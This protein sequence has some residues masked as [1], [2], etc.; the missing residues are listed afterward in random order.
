MYPKNYKEKIAVSRLAGLG[1]T[2]K[3][4]ETSRYGVNALYLMAH[5]I[6]E[7]AWGTV[8]LLSLKKIFM[9]LMRRT[10]MQKLMQTFMRPSKILVEAAQFITVG[11]KGNDG[12]TNKKQARKFNG[13][14][15]GNKKDGMNVRYASDPF[16]GEKYRWTYV[17]CR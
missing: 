2:F 1:S 10:I 15:L 16:W 12:S 9:A 5:A 14:Y 3:E 11:K 4:M 6:H 13:P 8:V 17:S 7:S